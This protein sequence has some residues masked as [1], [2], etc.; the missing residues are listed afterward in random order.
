MSFVTTQPA[1][2][3]SAAAAL[4]TIGSVMAAG[5]TAAAA[6]TTAVVPPAIDEVSVLT[7]AQFAAQAQ[8]YQ[9]LSAQAT[10]IHE[11]FVAAMTA[12]A[13]SYAATEAANAAS[14]F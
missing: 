9:A 1:M 11:Q 5:N 6:P 7:A 13:G 2:L 4:Q 10:A 14:V 12:S 3:E 8:T